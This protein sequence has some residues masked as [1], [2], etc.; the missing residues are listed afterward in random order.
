MQYT[1]AWYICYRKVTQTHEESFF[2]VLFRN[3]SHLKI[4][5][6]CFSFVIHTMWWL[7]P[8][9]SD[10]AEF[11][12]AA[13]SIRL[14]VLLN[15]PNLSTLYLPPLGLVEWMTMSRCGGLVLA[16]WWVVGVMADCG[17]SDAEE[18]SSPQ[19][20]EKIQEFWGW[21]RGSPHLS[22]WRHA[23]SQMYRIYP[24]F[25]L[26]SLSLTLVMSGVY[27]QTLIHGCSI[28]GYR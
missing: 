1:F 19:E 13:P 4:L 21:W 26:F 16:D 8:N 25:L 22:H 24:F 27:F 14:V 7:A 5:L 9:F 12:F 6:P 20:Q 23:E 3:V 10:G 18:E 11:E 17:V 15:G 28:C 2:P